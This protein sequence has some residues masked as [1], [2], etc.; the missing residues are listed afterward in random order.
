MRVGL[1]GVGVRLVEAKG[2]VTARELEAKRVAV[3]RFDDCLHPRARRY[4][5]T[6]TSRTLERSCAERTK[7]RLVHK[8]VTDVAA[9]DGA[10][11]V[12]SVSF[13]PSVD[14][15]RSELAER[16]CEPAVVVKV[17]EVAAGALGA[18]GRRMPSGVARQRARGSQKNLTVLDHALLHVVF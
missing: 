3:V 14:A 18:V 15:C 6:H 12:A 11:F 5:V 17:V 7:D 2:V 9:V 16:A 10:A 13:A 1:G 4:G 8:R